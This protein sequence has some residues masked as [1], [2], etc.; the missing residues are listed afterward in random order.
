M[1]VT[2]EIAQGPARGKRYSL[3]SKANF[4]VGRSRRAHFRGSRQDRY[5]SRI[6]FLIEVRPEGCRVLDMES[7]NGTFVN[8]RKVEAA[9]LKDGDLIRAGRTVLRF[10][11]ER[12]ATA[13]VG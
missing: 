13:M 6:H 1:Y 10:R 12:Q 8:G 3:N 5:F 2:L 7:R 9:D 4:M 11:L